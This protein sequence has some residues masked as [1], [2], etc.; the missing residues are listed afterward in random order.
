[1][2]KTNPNLKVFIITI[3]MALLFITVGANV[4][5]VSVLGIHINSKT[6]I[7]EEIEGIHV[8]DKTLTASRGKFLD[9][10]GA[11]IAQDKTAYTLYAN[12][13]PKRVTSKGNP[14][15]VVDKEDA[16][17]KI[18]AVINEDKQTVLN[19][20]NQEN[21]SQVEFGYKG[22]KLTVE[23]KEQLEAFEIPGLGFT[24]I[25]IRDYPFKHFASTLVGI[26]LFDEESK[27]IT[28]RFG[29][30]AIYDE[31]LL[32][33][34]G[35]KRYQQDKDGYILPQ[36]EVLEEA[37]IDGHNVKLT[38]DRTIQESLEMNLKGIA[39][40]EGVKA[41][42]LWG[43]VIEAK[44][45]KVVAWADYPSFDPNI[46]DIETYEN[47]GA[48]YTYEPGS[49][50]KTFTIAAAIDQ[51]VFDKDEKFDS[52]PFYVGVE[53]GKAVRLPNSQNS[54][55][56]ITNAMN[57]NYGDIT[58]EYGFD[59]SSNVMI[60]ELLTK[61]L[62]PEVFHDYLYKLGFFKTVDTDGIYESEGFDLWE[63]PLEKVSNG[64]GQGSTVTMLQMLQAYTSVVTDGTMVKPYF[65]E[66]IR[67]PNTDEVIY[68]GKT[69]VVGKPFKESTALQVRD[70][71]RTV[72]TRGSAQR[73]N[74]DEIEVIGKTGTA[75]MVVDGGY[76]ATDYIFSSALA[77]PYSDPE[78]IVYTAY[79]AKYGH[80]VDFSAKYVNEIVKKV[81]STYALQD[82][83]E[84]HVIKET[85][86]KPLEQFINMES[87]AA[88]NHLE[89]LNL[90]HVIIGDGSYIVDQYPK[91]GEDI[92]TN[93]LILLKTEGKQMTMPDMTGW[94]QK[95]VK[96][97]SHLTQIQIDIEGA[98][99]VVSQSAAKDAAI[100]QEDT[101][102]VT[103]Q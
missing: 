38:L 103:L 79:Q 32:G 3:V 88:K 66:E 21:V 102:T 2:K 20:L 16:A 70:N 78:Y 23:Q 60:A 97:F 62:D 71:M 40:D 75:Q 1:M 6:N 35:F 14:A 86:T 7:K 99:F 25:L 33:T 76:S 85:E 39:E 29:L 18:G 95:E 13:D 55:A 52:G 53:D 43:A 87:A 54:V 9:R 100:S 4:F 77:F 68:E 51:G 82:H 101:I 94:S 81:V 44:T 84:D 15:H 22:K 11:V 34:N 90:N 12:I 17:E 47:K 41:S 45:G 91:A 61:K 98:G 64:F 48:Q 10:N 19:I 26:S 5:V 56:T 83:E 67:D 65:V 24:P 46:L 80:D 59:I 28:G 58:Y 93:A 73:F 30:E 50:M 96:A 69:T 89:Q 37:P 31:Y 92:L 72:V 74:I 49:T 27:Q 63:W 42:E 8:V 36:V 57:V